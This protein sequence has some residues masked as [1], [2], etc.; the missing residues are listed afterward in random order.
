M[1]I[2]ASTVAVRSRDARAPASRRARGRLA[3]L[4]LALLALASS[5]AAGELHGQ[6]TPAPRV[7]EGPE[8]VIEYGMNAS[9]NVWW[10]RGIAFADAM[11]RASEFD[12]VIQG[13]LSRE[14]APLI[15]FGQVPPLRGAGWPDVA[16]LAPGEKAGARLFGRMAGSMPD[17]RVQPYVLTWG[18][19]GSCRL[20]GKGVVREANRSANRVEVFVDP[21]AAD[22][23]ALLAWLIDWSD[24]S[25]PVR[26]AHV[27]LPGME[28]TKPLLWPPFVEKLAAMNGGRGPSAWRAMD[29]NKVND[30][31]R[32]DGEAPFVFDLA[33]RIRPW[34]PS[35]GTRRGVCP[36]F[37]VAL[38]NAVGSGLHL[39]VPHNAD[40]LPDE[41]Y[42]FYLRDLFTRI[43]DGA[44]A[45]AGINGGKPFAPLAPDLKLTVE[46]SNEIWNPRFPVNDWLRKR[47]LLG[48]RKL[49]EEAALE[50]RRVFAVAEEVFSG[51]DAGRLRRFVG[52]WFDQPGFLEDVLDALGPDVQ[53]DALGPACYF[54]PRDAD[55]RAW[56]AGS[57]GQVC[58]RCPTPEEVIDS[59]R[60]S[61]AELGPKLLAHRLLAQARVNPDGSRARLELYEG[62]AS[63]DSGFQP[64][65][66]A[67]MQAQRLP[68]MY[69]AY[70]LDLV[71]TLIANGVD[72]IHWYSFITEGNQGTAGPFGHWL[73]MDQSITLP[74]PDVY[75]DEGLPKVAAIYKLPPRRPSPRFLPR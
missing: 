69:D 5:L 43:R 25:D 21:A 70:V 28:A 59:A 9:E 63:F 45:V 49:P 11:A 42:E 13:E 1:S 64:W 30:Y 8:F 31:G 19:R 54:A 48:G 7:Q 72:T 22:G 61:I 39:N 2:L 68:S 74:V 71:P 73:R 10:Q 3:G 60:A 4:R 15:P 20:D 55:V 14:P 38:C 44:P 33:G 56:L 23:N 62:G 53:V 26:A 17:G 6:A 32:H 65:G 67:A 41:L 51:P 18:G 35:Q 36:E 50:I 57:D 27:W 47:V 66:L 34:S 16:R 12:R 29:W 46:F 58:P 52:G 24:P 40:D 37:Q 75:V